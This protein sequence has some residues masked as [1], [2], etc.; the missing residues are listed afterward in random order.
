MPQRIVFTVQQNMSS[1]EAVCQPQS[2]TL[3][4]DNTLLT[5]A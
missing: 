5:A 1:Q 2:F 3:P 4:F